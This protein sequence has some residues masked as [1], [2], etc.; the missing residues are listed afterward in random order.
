VSR[1]YGLEI[2]TRKIKVVV[3][4]EGRD[5]TFTHNGEATEQVES[6]LFGSSQHIHRRCRAS[7]SVPD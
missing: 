2:S 3:T 5:H 1:D 7:K 6:P 4:S